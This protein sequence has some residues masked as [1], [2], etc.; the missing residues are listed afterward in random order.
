MNRPLIDYTLESLENAG[1]E[2]I[3]MYSG[4]HADQLERYLE[5]VLPAYQLRWG[6]AIIQTLTVS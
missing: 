6:C 1:V 3:I 2:E 4:A 5:Y